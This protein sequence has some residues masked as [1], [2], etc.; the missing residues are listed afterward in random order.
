[1]SVVGDPELSELGARLRGEILGRE[2]LEQALADEDDLDEFYHLYGHE[3]CYALV[4]ARDALT[5]RERSLAVVAMIAAQAPAS[6]TLQVHVRGAVRNGCS[7]AQLRQILA[8]VTW[9]AGVPV[10][11][12]ATATVRAALQSIP[13]A[14]AKNADAS[15]GDPGPG[16]LI[17]RGRELRRRVLGESPPVE[18]PAHAAH[19]V[20]ER[21]QDSHYFGMLWSN[22][23]L[24]LEQRSIVLLG[25]I[26]GSNRMDDAEIWLA[27]ALRVGCKREE[28]EEIL[29]SAAFYCGELVYARA[30]RAF[31]SVIAEDNG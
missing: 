23:D 1:M 30:R 16:D 2:R 24:T 14:E 28:L 29:L 7:R 9:Y 8:M 10:G 22:T 4:W 15:D 3:C 17:S 13:E 26:C 6:K 5:R 20:H 18:E 27:A 31:L 19:A 21:A 25:V 12:Q 11:S